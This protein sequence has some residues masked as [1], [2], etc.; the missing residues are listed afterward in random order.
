EGDQHHLVICAENFAAT[1]CQQGR[2]MGKIRTV[3]AKQQESAE[4]GRDVRIAEHSGRQVSLS[5][6]QPHAQNTFG[7]DNQVE[8][9]A[10]GKLTG[11]LLVLAEQAIRIL[12]LV[13][14]AAVGLNQSDGQM[15]GSRGLP[16][17]GVDTNLAVDQHSCHNRCK[18][19]QLAD[20]DLSVLE[21]LFNCSKEC[22]VDVDDD[23]SNPEDA[24]QIRDLCHE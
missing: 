4:E 14:G 19:Q 5:G 2:A 23:E 1:I 13:S 11:H 24:G 22:G 10:G 9:V 18:E 20:C 3:L 12:A 17:Y 6:L 21:P 16:V 15:F 8:L 7:P